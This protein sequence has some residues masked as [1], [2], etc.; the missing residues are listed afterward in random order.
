M[1]RVRE[2]YPTGISSLTEKIPLEIT[3]NFA[4]GS[5]FLRSKP[6]CGYQVEIEQ[7]YVTVFNIKGLVVCSVPCHKNINVARKQA[8]NILASI[9][10]G[11]P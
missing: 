2:P 5:T 1:T 4:C 6:L 7:G 9:L 3:W 11:T 10:Q 8:R